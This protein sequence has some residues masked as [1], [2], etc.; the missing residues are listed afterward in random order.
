M[1]VQLFEEAD[2][3]EHLPAFVSGNA[4]QFYQIAPPQKLVNLQRTAWR[5][6]ELYGSVRPFLAGQDLRWSMSGEQRKD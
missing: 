1:L 6:P 3:L 5:V 4:R 2:C